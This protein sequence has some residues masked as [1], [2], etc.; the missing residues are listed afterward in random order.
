MY[1]FFLYK[2]FGLP[3]TLV[4]IRKIIFSLKSCPLLLVFY[5]ITFHMKQRWHCCQSCIRR[6]CG[7][8]NRPLRTDLKQTEA[9]LLLLWSWNSSIIWPQWDQKLF[10]VAFEYLCSTPMIIYWI[11]K[12]HLPYPF[13]HNPLSI[14][15]RSWTLTIHKDRNFWKNLLENKEM[16]F[17]NGVKNIQAAAYNG[18]RT[19]NCFELS[20]FGSYCS[21]ICHVFKSMP[22]NL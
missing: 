7:P 4:I 15:N 18:A 20:C 12:I 22:F 5:G 8:Q 2:I 6:T 13:H 19:V 21:S 10:E 16:D 1:I 3:E 9:T 17:K 14:T 11:R